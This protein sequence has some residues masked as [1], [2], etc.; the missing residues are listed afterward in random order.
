MTDET[1]RESYRFT[2]DCSSG[3]PDEEFAKTI[4]PLLKRGQATKARK[5][6]KAHKNTAHSPYLLNFLG[7]AFSQEGK[8]DAAQ[9]AY[10]RAQDIRQQKELPQ[11]TP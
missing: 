1:L 8:A 4:I 7:D 6:L 5:Q 9:K 10:Q 2:Y 11:N 3:N